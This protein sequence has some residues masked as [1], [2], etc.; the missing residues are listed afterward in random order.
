MRRARSGRDEQPLERGP[1]AGP[2]RPAI[3][4]RRRGRRPSGQQR[5]RHNRRPPAAITI[6]QF[7]RAASSRARRPAV[8]LERAERRQRPLANPLGD[9]VR[10]EAGLLEQAGQRGCVTLGRAGSTPARA[11]STRAAPPRERRTTPCAASVLSI[12]AYAAITAPRGSV[13]ASSPLRLRPVRPRPPRPARG[14]RQGHGCGG[15]RAG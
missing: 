8:A 1:A 15:V 11:A 3:A 14:R 9:R 12:A 6:S 5:D 4:A 7:A 2:C 13:S 10:A